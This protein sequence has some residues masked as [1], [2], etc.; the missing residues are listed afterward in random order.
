MVIV[1]KN[2]VVAQ[3]V[4]F[5]LAQSVRFKR[6]KH[7]L[8]GN[9]R[10]FSKAFFVKGGQLMPVSK[11]AAKSRVSFVGWLLELPRRNGC[12]WEH[13]PNPSFSS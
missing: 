7:C 2:V 6:L 11:L 10:S 13:L 12:R 8:G 4:I 1:R 9:F 5:V 3:R